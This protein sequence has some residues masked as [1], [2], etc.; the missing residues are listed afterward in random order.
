MA[1]QKERVTLANLKRQ[2]AAEDP[3][4]VFVGTPTVSD[5]LGVSEKTLEAWRREGK[6]PRFVKIGRFIRYPLSGLV[7]FVEG[8]TFT[9]TRQAKHGGVR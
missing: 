4:L 8:R 7:G 6:G 5:C 2:Y 9:T 1:P 3:E